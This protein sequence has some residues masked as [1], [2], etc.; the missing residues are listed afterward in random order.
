MSEQN[1]FVYGTAV[2]RTADAAT[3]VVTQDGHVYGE[4]FQGPATGPPKRHHLAPT[5]WKN[6][7]GAEWDQDETGC[8]HIKVYRDAEDVT[9]EQGT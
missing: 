2:Y 9:P 6:V 4:S 8:W 5:P 3:I 1:G 7:P